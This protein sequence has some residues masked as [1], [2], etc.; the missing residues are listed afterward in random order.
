[1]AK[2]L[3][4]ESFWFDANHPLP[5][6][7]GQALRRLKDLKLEAVQVSEA[8]LESVTELG[9]SPLAWSD[10]P[11]APVDACTA[12]DPD[13]LLLCAISQDEKLEE[14]WRA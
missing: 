4:L 5:A 10:V 3:N 11:V 7:F 8:G 6:P 2:A 1:M 12:T 9:G 13:P 14:R